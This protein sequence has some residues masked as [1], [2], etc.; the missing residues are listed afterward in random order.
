MRR[1]REWSFVKVNCLRMTKSISN[2]NKSPL[3]DDLTIPRRCFIY[4]RVQRSVIFAH[5]IQSLSVQQQGPLVLFNVILSIRAMT[6][7]GYGWMARDD[8]R[9]LLLLLLLIIMI[10]PLVSQRTEFININIRRRL[11]GIKSTQCPTLS[12]R[13]ASCDDRRP[14]DDDDNDEEEQKGQNGWNWW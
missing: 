9:L 1:G 5:S 10:V 13:A 2:N 4:S 8:H 6:A 14:H 12:L 7:A 11:A 3:G